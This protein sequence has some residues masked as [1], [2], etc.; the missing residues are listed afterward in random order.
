MKFNKIHQAG[1]LLWLGTGLYVLLSGVT[2]LFV[3]MFL[4]FALYVF[5]KLPIPLFRKLGEKAWFYGPFYLVTAVSAA[6]LVK[7]FLLEICIIPSGSMENTLFPHDRV[8]INKLSYGPRMPRSI[9]ETPWIHGLYLLFKGGDAYTQALNAGKKKDFRRWKGF[10]GVNRGDVIVFESP[11]KENL[12]LVK[13]FVALPGDTILMHRGELYVN[14]VRQK[15]PVKSKARYDVWPR[16]PA[17]AIDF[18]EGLSISSRIFQ[19]GSSIPWK[20]VLDQE[21]YD[22]IRQ[23]PFFDSVKISIPVND[24]LPI[25]WHDVSSWS[26]NDFGPL[27]IPSKGFRIPINAENL[28]RYQKLVEHFEK[29]SMDGLESYTFQQDYYFSMGDNRSNSIDSRKWGLIPEKGVIGKA[30]LVLYSENNS[31]GLLKRMFR[32]IE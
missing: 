20:C 14:G 27:I 9:V 32:P 24:T 17:R 28:Q 4:I 29:T 12:L 6:I 3:G 26:A 21:K 15:P 1:S 5:L 22:L 23:S 18:L 30:Y 8:I 2:W 19:Q 11:Q 10:S 31:I 7:V 25:R 13:R 16:E